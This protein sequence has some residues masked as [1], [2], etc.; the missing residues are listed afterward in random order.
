VGNWHESP[1]KAMLLLILS[2]LLNYAMN[3]VVL[4][5]PAKRLAFPLGRAARDLIGFTLL[6][7]IADRLGVVVGFAVATVV[8]ILCNIGGQGGIGYWF[9][10]GAVL[11]FLFCGIAVG[12][13]SYHYLKRRW[14]LPITPSRW[15]AL[16][17]G[18]VTNPA[19]L[20]L[21]WFG[22]RH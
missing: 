14:C 6:A 18:F 17:A 8:A 16:A 22:E 13:L 15:V 9:L 7:Q 20:M 10:I 19:W 3:V 12:F 2:L 1:G 4:A 11:N 21:A 5:L